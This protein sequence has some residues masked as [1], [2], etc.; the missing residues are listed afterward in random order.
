MAES[1]LNKRASGN[2]RV[3]A[4]RERGRAKDKRMPDAP[5]ASAD[6]DP[7]L[8][9]LAVLIP[10]APAISD[11]TV[12]DAVRDVLG[13]SAEEDDPEAVE[14]AIRTGSVAVV[15]QAGWTI[16]VRAE[17]RPLF[18]DADGAARDV[19]E[20]RLRAAVEGHAGFI[21]VDLYGC[22]EEIG[23]RERLASLGRVLARL[24]PADA[25][26][27]HGGGRVGLFTPR[28]ARALTDG[29]LDAALAPADAPVPIAGVEGDDP[30][31]TAAA[32][33]ANRRIGEFLTA[34]SQRQPDD[35]FAVKLPFA[36]ASG[37]EY[38]WVSVTAIDDACFHGRLDNQPAFVTTVRAGQTV[39]V[40]RAKL[41]DWLYVR[42]G[43]LH[44][45]FTLRLLGEKLRRPD[46]ARD[47]AV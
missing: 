33:E 26:A 20:L 47:E 34:F 40:P 3:S 31:M 44:G 36:D 28:A 8:A 7:V 11:L 29:D 39:H 38:M 4:C 22:P 19:P 32:A 5:A 6:G 23:A 17:A 15:R 18:A 10:A 30:R 14:F 42:G 2:R 13:G 27:L 46:R 1:E 43:E 16:G 37:L 35:T 41:N 24:A 45:G 12:R 25:L 21:A 9:S